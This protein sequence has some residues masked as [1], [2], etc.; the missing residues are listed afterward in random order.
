MSFSTILASL[1]PAALYDSGVAQ[2]IAGALGPNPGDSLSYDAI[3]LTPAIQQLDGTWLPSDPTEPVTHRLA[4]GPVRTEFATQAQAL[5]ASPAMLF[6]VITQRL[7]ADAL[8][9]I[10]CQQFCTD[11]QLFVDKDLPEIL[12]ASNLLIIEN[13]SL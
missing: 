8:T 2:K 13:F 10:E 1:I 3:L 4:I 12:T 7:G 9:L 6:A 5:Y 11:S